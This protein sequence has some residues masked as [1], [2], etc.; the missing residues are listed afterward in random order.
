MVIINF[1]KNLIKNKPNTIDKL[2][3]LESKVIEAKEDWQ[4]AQKVCDEITDQRYLDIAILKVARAERK[5][6]HYL[7]LIKESTGKNRE[8]EIGH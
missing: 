8:S 4:A 6:I 1:L 7:K 2:D 3:E 5:Y